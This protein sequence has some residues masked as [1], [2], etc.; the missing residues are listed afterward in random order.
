M[1]CLNLPTDLERKGGHSKGAFLMELAC[2]PKD[3]P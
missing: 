1:T 2:E 3:F